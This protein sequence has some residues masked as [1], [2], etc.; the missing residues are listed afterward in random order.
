MN[1]IVNKQLELGLIKT[2]SYLFVYKTSQVW[3][4]EAYLILFNKEAKSSKKK[5]HEQAREQ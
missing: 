2:R 3:A 1:Q 5:F 4:L